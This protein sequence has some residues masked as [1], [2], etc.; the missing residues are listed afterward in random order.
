MFSK[1]FKLIFLLILTIVVEIVLIWEYERKDY[2]VLFD[3]FRFYLYLILSI[4]HNDL[5]SSFSN[6]IVI[7][8]LFFFKNFEKLLCGS[9]IVFLSNLVVQLA[10]Q[11]HYFYYFDWDNQI[12]EIFDNEKKNL[13]DVCWEGFSKCFESL[14][15]IWFLK[16]FGK[17]SLLVNEV[18]GL[19]PW[20]S[21]CFLLFFG[22]DCWK[23]SGIFLVSIIGPSWQFMWIG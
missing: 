18:L 6:N 4:F 21:H 8:F 20:N 11:I 16:V 14:D 22:Q 10:F 13:W 1:S 23:I 12:Y 15:F 5:I 3:F 19:I 2:E 9:H 17:F 7:I